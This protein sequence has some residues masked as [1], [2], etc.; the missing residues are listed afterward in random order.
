MKK[1]YLLLILMIGFVSLGFIQ[2]Q[3]EEIT[4]EETLIYPISYNEPISH[5]ISESELSEYKLYFGIDGIPWLVYDFSNDTSHGFIITYND[6][7]TTVEFSKFEDVYSTDSDEIIFSY[8]EFLPAV[9][10]QNDIFVYI[11]HDDYIADT[12][13]FNPY[14]N[15]YD[16]YHIDDISN[17]NLYVWQPYMPISMISTMENGIIMH[18]SEFITDGTSTIKPRYFTEINYHAVKGYYHFITNNIWNEEL[19]I[20]DDGWSYWPNIDHYGDIKFMLKRKTDEPIFPTDP[21]EKMTITSN[22]IEYN[23]PELIDGWYNFKIPAGFNID[24]SYGYLSYKTSYEPFKNI[25]ESEYVIINEYDINND[26]LDIDIW[27]KDGYFKL[28]GLVGSFDTEIIDIETSD[29]TFLSSNY[30]IYSTLQTLQEN[31]LLVYT[32]FTLIS[33]FIIFLT[34]KLFKKQRRY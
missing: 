7:D 17:Y 8:T 21:E 22:A 19:Y 15:F 6:T 32:G 9:F 30:E 28:F 23:D 16:H 34:I 13:I 29:F 5:W 3:A 33:A 24:V 14:N 12:V 10:I 2:V 27:I 26:V 1:I 18:A 4:T 31:K 11:I 20:F 25:E